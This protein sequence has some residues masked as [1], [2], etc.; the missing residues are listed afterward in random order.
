MGCR[1]DH[2][3]EALG[4]RCDGL[5]L[6]GGDPDSARNAGDV[7][8]AGQQDGRSKRSG[9]VPNKMCQM[10]IGLYGKVHQMGEQ[11]SLDRHSYL[12]WRL[13]A[14]GLRRL[15]K[16]DN[17]LGQSVLR[18]NRRRVLRLAGHPDDH[19]HGAW[20]SLAHDNQPDQYPHVWLPRG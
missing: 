2:S 15:E 17:E 1:E 5:L 7:L 19:H 16:D 13:L 18:V 11:K 10:F 14:S 8:R 9:Q 20:L 4:K 12:R 3:D 6:R